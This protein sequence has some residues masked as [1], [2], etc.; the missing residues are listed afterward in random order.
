MVVTTL[1]RLKPQVGWPYQRL[2]ESVGLPYANFRRWKR[3]L[4][5]GQPALFKPGPKKV[6]PLNLDELRGHLCRLEHGRRRPVSLLHVAGQRSVFGLLYRTPDA[7]PVRAVLELAAAGA[8]ATDGRAA[9]WGAVL[10]NLAADRHRHGLDRP[11][12]PWPVSPDQAPGP[13]ALARRALRARRAR[14]PL[15]WRLAQATL[16]ALAMIAAVVVALPQRPAPPIANELATAATSSPAAPP[17]APAPPAPAPGA[18]TGRASRTAQAC[19]APE[20]NRG[21]RACRLPASA[22]AGRHPGTAARGHRD[23]FRAAYLRAAALEAA[24]LWA[25]DSPGL[26]AWVTGLRA[27][28][29]WAGRSRGRCHALHHGH[30]S[31]PP[32]SYRTSFR[33]AN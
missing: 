20:Q 1:T 27:T 13:I 3:R 25:L 23:Q 10:A 28:H 29:Q 15:R 4:A 14:Y 31:R 6:A 16:A 18:G 19:W 12:P 30:G 32:D 33:V 11:R 21:P 7:A 9:G 24:P 8:A 2:C 17:A 5:R 26:H 22:P